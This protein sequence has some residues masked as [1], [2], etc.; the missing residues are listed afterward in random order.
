MAFKKKLYKIVGKDKKIHI[1]RP[2]TD[3]T[4]VHLQ[5]GKRKAIVP[6]VDFEVLWDSGGWFHYLRMDKSRKVIETYKGKWFWTGRVVK[7]IE[8]LLDK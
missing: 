7:G 6:I 8:K 3:A 1:P 4:H 5:I 2:P